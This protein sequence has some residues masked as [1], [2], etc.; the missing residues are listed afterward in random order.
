MNTRTGAIAKNTKATTYTQTTLKAAIST[1][2]LTTLIM[3]QSAGAYAQPLREPEATKKQQI[4]KAAVVTSTATFGALAGGPLGFAVG[5]IS[6][7]FINDFSS[8]QDAKKIAQAESMLTISELETTVIAQEIKVEEL[9]K[10][11]HQKLQLKIQ[12][13]TGSDTLTT[14]DEEN[15]AALSEILHDDATLNVRLDGYTDPRGTDEYN[16][17]LSLE[18]AKSV[19]AILEDYGINPERID[20]N[21]H[22]SKYVPNILSST[23][24]TEYRRVDIETYMPEERDNTNDSFTHVAVFD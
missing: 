1:T 20:I 19:A 13:D 21:G 15:L 10:I 17:V 8:K 11:A 9:E 14:S 22:G 7:A 2:L 18:R 4:E 23:D 12:F 3:A 16:N 5:L 24:Y 6:G